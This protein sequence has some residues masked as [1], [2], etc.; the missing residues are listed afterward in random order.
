MSGTDHVRSINDLSR[1][2]CLRQML[3]SVPIAGSAVAC[4]V[5]TLLAPA[6]Q[7]CPAGSPEIRMVAEAEDLT[8]EELPA[9]EEVADPPELAAQFPDDNPENIAPAPWLAGIPFPGNVP[10]SPRS[11]GEIALDAARS[12]LGSDYVFG[13]TGPDAFDCSGLVQWSYQQAGVELPRTSYEQLAVGTP[14]SLDELR[15]G[16]LVSFYDG[17]HSALYAGEGEV[18]HASTEGVGVIMSPLS[19]M[20]IA[21]AR[22]F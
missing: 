20:P 7:A 2:R 15:L 10:A 11:A 19:D 8:V 3:W 5:T 16:D 9:P 1:K 13:E 17:D 22:R 21:G 14:V 4:A 6:A 18:I 12:K